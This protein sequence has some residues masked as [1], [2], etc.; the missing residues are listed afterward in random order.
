[1]EV[2]SR[3]S[4]RPLTIVELDGHGASAAWYLGARGVRASEIG[5]DLE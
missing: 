5:I 2:R 3:T 1:M 4:D